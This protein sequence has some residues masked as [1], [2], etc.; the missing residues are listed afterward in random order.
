M[1]FQYYFSLLSNQLLSFSFYISYP[2]DLP[3]NMIA[4]MIISYTY[5]ITTKFVK[6]KLKID[7]Q[8]AF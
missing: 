4:T 6:I 2:R 5:L 1:Y 7:M 8:T 3:W